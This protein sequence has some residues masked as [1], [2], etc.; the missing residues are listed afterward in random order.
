[1]PEAMTAALAL[2]QT[3]I[4]LHTARVVDQ[5]R[6]FKIGFSDE[7]AAQRVAG[8][9]NSAC[10]VALFGGDMRGRNI[11]VCHDKKPLSLL[12]F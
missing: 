1:M 9:Q 11:R 12:Q 3:G 2:I 6:V 7:L 5:H 10:E 8:H 4:A